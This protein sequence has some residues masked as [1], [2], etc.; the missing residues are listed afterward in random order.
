MSMN[1]NKLIIVIGLGKT[2]IS[3]IRYLRSNGS[4]VIAVD[5]RMTPPAL[6]ELKHSFP[7]VPYY[8]GT[9]D[10]QLFMQASVLAVSPGI[11]TKIPA[12]KKCQDNG[13]EI[14][15]D[16]E[17][18][19]RA[20]KKPIVA[21]TGSNGKSTV[22]T[23]VGDILKNY[24]KRVGMGGNL[25]TSALDLLNQEV[26]YYVLELSSFQLETTYS[27]QAEVATV[28]N[29]SED[30]MDRYQNLAEYREA[31]LRIY[32]GATIQVINFDDPQ[33]HPYFDTS[34]NNRTVSFSLDNPD[35]DFCLQGDYLLNCSKKIMVVDELKIRGRHNVSNALAAMAIGHSLGVPISSMAT[36]LR[37][38]PGLDHRCQWVRIIAGVSWYNDSKGTNVGATEAAIAG[39]GATLS[40]KKIILIAGG[41]GK[42]ADFSLLLDVLAKY[43]KLT[44]LLGQDAP[45]IHRA[46]E[47]AGN[48]LY[49]DSM[50][51]AVKL[52]Y[53]NARSGDIVL[54]SPACASFD[55]FNNFEH[56]GD[57]FISEVNGI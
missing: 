45:L 50:A 23:L 4:K 7:D 2:G 49:A 11:S 57:V 52:A 43:V 24:G 29:L 6:E 42:G 48:L 8:L 27:L 39:L 40:G 1:N 41:V 54:L 34:Y 15:G 14:I 32:N 47:S 56:R 36:T 37:S 35:A 33:L 21:I 44:I 18:F 5:N 53:D 20:A 10:E 22:T 26:D 9:F 13:I 30:H 28:L 17:L 38:F 31:K 51:S 16:I 25:G 55:M 19:A 46:L 12:I 3:V